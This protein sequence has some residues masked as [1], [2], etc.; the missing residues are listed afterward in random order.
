MKKKSGGRG[1]YII[2][3]I[4]ILAI[5]IL[6]L[7]P[8]LFDEAYILYNQGPL[9]IIH[10]LTSLSVSVFLFGIL[11]DSNAFIRGDN[12]RGLYFQL[13]GS[14]AGFVVFFYLLSTG[15]S[16]SS[17]LA[18]TLISTDNKVIRDEVRLEVIGSTYQFAT[19]DNGFVD[20]SY[21]PK[22]DETRRL[23]LANS[24]NRAWSILDILPPECNIRP[25]II[26][27][28]CSRVEIVADIERSC[29]DEVRVIDYEGSN[30]ITTS[31]SIKLERLKEKFQTHEPDSFFL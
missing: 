3:T 14:A 20:I 7:L 25:S 11:G 21:L 15:L 19:F 18:A 1:L 16:G 27:G 23:S 28:S 30:A 8:A 24:G 9:T 22:S 5:F 12:N 17:K 4:L 13:G 26:K 29:L 2:G 10:A 31:L 6:T